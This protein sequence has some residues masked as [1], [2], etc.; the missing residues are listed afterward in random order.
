MESN[1]VI[2]SDF[3]V[4]EVGDKI[5]YQFARRASENYELISVTNSEGTIVDI[6][7]QHIVVVNPKYCGFNLFRHQDLKDMELEVIGKREFLTPVLDVQLKPIHY[8]MN[9]FHY[10]IMK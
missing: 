9:R 6:A 3:Y 8:F 7:M 1:G 5:R 4:F 2:R 10:T